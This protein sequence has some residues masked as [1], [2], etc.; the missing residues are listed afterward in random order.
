MV[1]ER[2]PPHERRGD[3]G[4]GRIHLIE[5]RVITK[6]GRNSTILVLAA[7]QPR[8]KRCVHLVEIASQ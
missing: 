2:E 3:D 5:R 8:R 4:V 1:K 7:E 6:P